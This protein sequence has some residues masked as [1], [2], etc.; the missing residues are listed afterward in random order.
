MTRG[1]RLLKGQ[2]RHEVARRI[3][4][5]TSGTSDRCF[6]W[7]LCREVFVDVRRVIESDA[8]TPVVREAI[9]LRMPLMKAVE[10]STVT[11][12][13]LR[14]GHRGQIVQAAFVL[15]M[16]HHA[17][18]LAGRR[19]RRMDTAQRPRAFLET[20]NAHRV[21]LHRVRADVVALEAAAAVIKAQLGIEDPVQHA[22]E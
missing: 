8:Q 9:E 11:R 18:D 21:R 20:H 17:G 2:A 3:D 4:R 7:V 15:D 10:P 13:A 14:L 12:L 22:L 16:A 19:N 6:V 5:V 1:A